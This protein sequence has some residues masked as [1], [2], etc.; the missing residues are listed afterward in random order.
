M[1]LS[2]TADEAT[3][4]AGRQPAS[5]VLRSAEAANSAAADCW[6]ALLAGCDSVSRHALLARLRELSEATS[7]YAGRDWWFG[8][9]ARHRRRVARTQARI[10]EAVADRDGA[11]FAEAFVGYDQAVATAV[12]CVPKTVG[13]R[14]T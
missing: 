10:E 1:T 4:A 13:S 11:D 6:T 5:A 7:I 2:V 12:V 14:T 9:G 8:E 3:R